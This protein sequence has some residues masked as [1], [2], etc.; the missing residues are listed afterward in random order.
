MCCFEIYVFYVLS[1]LWGVREYKEDISYSFYIL[2]FNKWGK[3]LEE[4]YDYFRGF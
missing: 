3:I 4:K 2:N 1:F